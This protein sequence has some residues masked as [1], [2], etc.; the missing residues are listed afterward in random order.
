MAL[1]RRLPDD[2]FR[3][4]SGPNRHVYVDILSRLHKLFFSDS[5]ASIFPS[6]K[7]VR[8]EIEETLISLSLREWK[9]EEDDETLPDNADNTAG[10]A[11]RAY[12]RLVR[13]GWLEEEQEGYATRV[14]I[15]SDVGR[16]LSALL[17]ISSQRTRLYGGIVQ[18]IYNNI[19]Q[20]KEKPEEQAA[21]FALVEAARQAHEFFLHLRSLEYGLRDLTKS[22]KDIHDPKKL[23]GS[24]F[25]DFVEEFLVADYKTLHTQENP[26]R[27]R[28]EIIRIVRELRF[29]NI[30]TET[31][32]AAYLRLQIVK[33]RGDALG[34]VDRDFQ[35]LQQV[36]EEADNHL[37]RIDT[38]R[39]SLERRVAESIRYLDKT[40]PGM[41][42][43]L[44]RLTSRLAGVDES[45]LC[46]Y[47][48]LHRMARI[49]PLSPKSPR[50]PS[51]IKQ[52]PAPQR[53]RIRLPNPAHA[54]R[55]KAIREYQKRRQVDPKRIE[56]YLERNLSSHNEISARDLSIET[57]A[58]FMAFAHLRRLDRFAQMGKAGQH[59]ANSYSVIPGN[60]FHEN[61]WFR[62]MDFT[63]IRKR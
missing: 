16:L 15:P 55:L 50:S 12:R 40:Q 29:S 62:F 7:T 51:S 41:A 53:L 31:L 21:A 28:T 33:S 10:H 59:L 30:A 27:F 23:L 19:R 35:V 38:Y 57:V 5:S 54:E 11:W 39:S 2:L 34:R 18:S 47:P 6:D 25:N 63:V 17:E 32:P 26:F 24:F 56:E 45:M 1:F 37:A 46:T 22:L 44:A 60:I 58:D 52:P 20:V 36:F 3:P 8:T 43:R 4:L 9:H 61:Q 13:C 48:P 14:V 42:A 49:L